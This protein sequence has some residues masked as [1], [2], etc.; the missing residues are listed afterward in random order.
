MKPP[1][2][3]NVVISE[4]IFEGLKV[5]CS[6]GAKFGTVLNV[7]C[8]NENQRLVGPEIVFCDDYGRWNDPNP[9]YECGELKVIFTRLFIFFI[10]IVN[11]YLFERLKRRMF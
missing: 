6:S 11:N 2:S 9:M 10:N 1:V 7:K 8:L 3:S 5:D 4:F